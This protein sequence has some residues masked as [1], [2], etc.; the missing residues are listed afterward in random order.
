MKITTIGRGHIGGGLGRLWVQAGH[1]VTAH[2]RDGGDA[3]DADAVFVAGS[4]GFVSEALGK[5]SGCEGRI[6]ID[7]T[8]ALAG[9]MSTSSERSGSRIASY[10]TALNVSLARHRTLLVLL[11][12]PVS[13]HAARLVDRQHRGH[14]QG[15]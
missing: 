1:T 9:A 4:V 14:E 2:G 11:A 6:A 8:T 3:A 10:S 5:V 13:G 12:L 7:A 15:Q